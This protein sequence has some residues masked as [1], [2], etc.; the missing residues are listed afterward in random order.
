MRTQAK[1]ETNRAADLDRHIGRKL[2]CRRRL[3]KLSV[4]EVALKLGLPPHQLVEFEDGATR[5]RAKYL[6][7]LTQLLGVPVSYFFESFESPQPP[8]G[9]V[10]SAIN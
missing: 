5:V 6:A 9:R 3:L 1:S 10:N 4:D 8:M 7:R 2:R